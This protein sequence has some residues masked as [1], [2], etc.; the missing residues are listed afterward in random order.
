VGAIHAEVV[1]EPDGVLGL[2]GNAGRP[3]VNRAGAPA[4]TPP[5]VADALEALER[6][7]RHQRLQRVGDVRAVDEQHRLTRP[8]DLIPQFDAVDLGVF[9]DCSSVLHPSFQHQHM[10]CAWSPSFRIVHPSGCGW[11]SDARKPGDP[12]AS[13]EAPNSEPEGCG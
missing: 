11:C 2:H 5:V 9:H 13:G 3:R 1:E 6:R 8:H 12:A 7:F 4:Q 10:A